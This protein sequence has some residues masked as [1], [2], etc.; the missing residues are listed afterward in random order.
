MDIRPEA[1]RWGTTAASELPW[2]ET[3][4]WHANLAE[5]TALSRQKRDYVSIDHNQLRRDAYAACLP[6]Y[7]AIH[8][9]RLA[10]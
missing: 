7:Q 5:S 8:A 4:T 10:R 9:H 1:L 2:Y 6:H 3:G